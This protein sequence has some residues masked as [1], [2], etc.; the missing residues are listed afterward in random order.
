MPRTNPSA[1]FGTWSSPIT[2]EAV[3]A[4]VVPLAEP[5]ADG[6][7]IYWI[8]GRPLEG[9]RNVIMIRRGNGGVDCLTKAPFDA[10]TQVHSYG[11]GAYAVHAGIVYFVNCGDNQIYREDGAH[12]APARITAGEACLYADIC[13]DSARNRLI[14]VKEERPN[15]DVINSINSLGSVEIDSGTE[16]VLD[17]AHDFYSSPVLNPDGSKLAWLSWNHP[18]MPWTSTQLNVAD[19]DGHSLRNKRAVVC[20]NT[21]SVFQP[22]WSPDGTLYFISD[23]TDFWNLYRWTGS[24]VEAMLPRDAEFGVPQW[25]FGASTYAFVSAETLIYSFTRNGTWYLG[26]LDTRTR[27]ASDFTSEFASVSGVRAR[28]NGVVLLCSNVDI[29]YSRRDI[30]R[31]HGRALPDQIFDPTAAPAIAATLF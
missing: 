3:A 15:G 29:A 10:R 31:R 18:D 2:A 20:G 13:F 11:G 26:R 5:R 21:K 22:Q 6:D 30:G 14:A 12:A 8:E 16:T 4:V 24:S 7:D 1:S 28:K 17:K 25:V 19:I 27:A 23:R 9:G